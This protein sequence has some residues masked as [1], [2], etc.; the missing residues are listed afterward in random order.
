[1]KIRLEDIVTSLELS[2]KL[3]DLGVKQESIFCYE[4]NWIGDNWHY[5]IRTSHGY[6][7]L[8]AFTSEE[9]GKLLPSVIKT[10]GYEYHLTIY[11]YLLWCIT[12]TPFEEER[13]LMEQPIK[14]QTETEA[15]AKMLIY[16]IEN[17]LITLEEK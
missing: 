10:S 4:R 12:Y 13:L 7:G 5:R 15:K 14:A 6:H 8:A 3:K 17:K 9:L 11:K 1:M 2:N 16:L